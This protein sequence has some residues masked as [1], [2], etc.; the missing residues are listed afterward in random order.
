MSEGGLGQERQPI[1]FDLFPVGKE[2]ALN[3]FRNLSLAE[4]PS[5]AQEAVI[6]EASILN[7]SNPYVFAYF[8]QMLGGFPPEASKTTDQILWGALIYHQALREEARFRGGRLPIVTREFLQDYYG[9]EAKAIV[10]EQKDKKMSLQEAGTQL[11]KM[12][13]IEFEHTEPEFSKIVREKL[14]VHP[15]WRPEEDPRYLGIIHMH[16]LFK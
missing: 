10:S 9:M 2:A 4:N 12:K 6:Q 8:L 1:I 5:G 13:Q 16:F 15:G 14:G 7:E 11:R 3:A